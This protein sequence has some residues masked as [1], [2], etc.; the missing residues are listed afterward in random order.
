MRSSPRSSPPASTRSTTRSPAGSRPGC[1]AARHERRISI[2]MREKSARCDGISV[3]SAADRLAVAPMV[4]AA[5]RALEDDEGAWIVGGAVRDAALGREVT[6]LDLAVAGDPRGAARAIAPGLG[7]HAFQLSAEV[8][9]WRVVSPDH[10][11]QVDATAL[12][13]S[14][15]EA[16]LAERDFTIGAVAVPV[17]G[18]ETVD[19]FG[20]L[21]DLER[22]LLRAVGERSFSAD[23]L[24]LLRAAR[25]AAELGLR[26]DPGTAELARAAASRASDP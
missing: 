7:G 4:A 20:G 17:A 12:H 23:P 3:V 11:W 13:G 18:G 2:A 14:G 10:G 24:R 19:P 15:I 1:R 21:A 5:R 25:L 6:D 26:I 9:T 8:G 16:D 22:R